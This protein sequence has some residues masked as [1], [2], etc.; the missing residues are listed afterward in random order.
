MSNLASVRLRT[1]VGYRAAEKDGATCTLNDGDKASRADVIIVGKIDT[2][3]DPDRA[4]RWRE[5]LKRSKAARIKIIIDYTDHHLAIPSV[6]ADFYT[7]ALSLADLVVCSSHQLR[8]YL[9]SHVTCKIEVIE[10]P[11]EVPIIP[12]KH[13]LGER[14]T[15]LWF[16]HSTN[17]EP[18]LH[19][20]ID[21]FDVGDEA[22]VIVLTNLYPLPEDI[23]NLLDLPNLANIEINII[24]WSTETLVEAT[25]LSDFCIIPA[26]LANPRKNGASSNRLL[27]ALA[28]G[29][30]TLASPLPSY[31]PY[32]SAFFNLEKATFKASL[33]ATQ[34]DTSPISRIQQQIATSHTKECIAKAW[35]ELILRTVSAKAMPEDKTPQKSTVTE[36]RLN[37]GCGDKIIDGY[38]NVDVVESRGGKKPD[39]LCDLHRLTV[40]D[41]EFAD[42]ILAVHVV[43]HFWQWEIVEILKEWTRVLKPGGRMILECPNLI[44]AAQEFLKD[45]DRA[46][47]GG[48]EGQRSM[49]VFYGDPGWRDP[50]MIHRW[51]YTPRSLA[52]VMQAAGLTDIRQEPAQFKL[53]EPRDMRIT[54]RKPRHT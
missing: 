6:T 24:S 18:L 7:E 33:R 19:C 5:H 4:R 46:A 23:T 14:K 54:A 44:S 1:V 12:P 39:V 28:L 34:I 26:D 35:S 32:S 21:F 50:L 3:T 51:G 31:E 16:G 45:P 40:F 20:L 13:R 27:T 47:L 15:F 10:D 25:S 37:L 42:E 2:V 48:P 9:E 8:R 53:R 22:R 49:W 29:L 11:I 38:I 36:V 17:I 43:E 41:D 30:P 52:A